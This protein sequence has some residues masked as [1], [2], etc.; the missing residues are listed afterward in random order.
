M[1]F[2]H[3]LISCGNRI[4]IATNTSKTSFEEFMIAQHCYSH[5][6]RYLPLNKRAE[7]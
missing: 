1:L 2:K 3:C 6:S 7:K 4:H 5:R